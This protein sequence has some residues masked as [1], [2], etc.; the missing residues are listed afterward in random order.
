MRNR[1]MQIAVA[2]VLGLGLAAGVSLAQDPKPPVKKPTIRQRQR[3]Q[4]KRIAEGVESGQLTPRETAKIERQEGQ[5]NR[6]IR[7]DRNDGDGLGPRER[8]KIQRQQNKLSRE[9]YR[10]KHDGEKVPPAA[11][12]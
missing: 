2:G 9:I 8:A 3:N 10:E 4:Q 7:R 6:E 5:L 11:Q 12:K 1:W